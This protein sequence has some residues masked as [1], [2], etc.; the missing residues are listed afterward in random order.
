MDCTVPVTAMLLSIVAAE[1]PEVLKRL[2]ERVTQGNDQKRACVQNVLHGHNED[3]R[4]SD[5]DDMVQ[6]M[7]IDSESDCGI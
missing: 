7:V 5:H 3:S 1:D 6:G 2:M 4:C